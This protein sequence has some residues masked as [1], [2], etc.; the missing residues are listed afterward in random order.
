[1]TLTMCRLLPPVGWRLPACLPACLLTQV[2]FELLADMRASGLRP[3]TATCSALIY[4]CLVNGDLPAARK[5]YD[6]L[7]ARGVTPHISQYNA[8]LEQYALRFQLGNV[9]S[10]VSS[11]AEYGVA[12]NANT[13]RCGMTAAIG[14]QQL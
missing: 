6:T 1:M 5:V 13:F 9:V 8:L 11:M 3:S 12:P 10:L 2:A 4:A 14:A 7:L